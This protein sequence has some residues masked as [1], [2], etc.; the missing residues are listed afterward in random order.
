MRWGEMRE[1]GLPGGTRKSVYDSVFFMLVYRRMDNL[2]S[3]YA[4]PK[5]Y[6]WTV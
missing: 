5:I 3:R 6:C 1:G 2:L 4:L